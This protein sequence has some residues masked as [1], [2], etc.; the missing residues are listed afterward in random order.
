MSVAVGDDPL[1]AVWPSNR[2]GATDVV[3]PV[4]HEGA[5]VGE[6]AVAGPGLGPADIGILNQLAIVSAPSLRSIG[7]LADLRSVQAAIA[8]QNQELAASRARL[9]A[10][11]DAERMRLAEVIT[12]RLEPLL[13]QIGELLPATVRDLTVRPE[14]ADRDL[15]QLAGLANQVVSDLREVSRGVLPRL[16]VDHGLGAALRALVRRIDRPITLELS[17]DVASARFPAP[18]RR[19]S[20]CVAGTR[21]TTSARRRRYGCGAKMV[22]CVSGSG[23][24]TG[25]N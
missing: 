6:I 15:A 4:L 10:A 2:D 21:S 16:I 25:R 1:S 7:L 8:E 19:P 9:V 20:T 5:P 12:S 14:D 11:A 23:A 18:V 13:R 3:V 24:V 17:P 22:D